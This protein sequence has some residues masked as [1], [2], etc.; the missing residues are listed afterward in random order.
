MFT[1]NLSRLGL[2]C[3]FA[4]VLASSS[5]A[6]ASGSA[7]SL[8][9]SK[10]PSG[11]TLRNANAKQTVLALKAAAAEK[12]DMAVELLQAAIL[13]KTKPDGK[14]EY[15]CKVLVQ[16]VDAA[17]A[18]APAKTNEITEEALSLDPDCAD[19]LN[20][21]L[22]SGGRPGLTGTS[23][24]P[25]AVG[26]EVGEGGLGA[27]MGTGFPGSPGFV[28]SAPGGTIALPPVGVAV[29]DVGSGT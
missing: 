18:A 14:F 10:L 3:A 12:P 19:D 15:G 2:S 1:S 4:T 22:T 26:G 20:Q 11:L 5:F 17:S 25:N 9:K 6:A 27:G 24:D 28:G 16:L 13:G 8:L 29:T 7:G 21:Y 23:A